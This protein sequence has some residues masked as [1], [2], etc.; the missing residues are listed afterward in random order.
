MVQYLDDQAFVGGVRAF[1]KEVFPEVHTP[2]F[3]P[4]H[5]HFSPS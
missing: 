4:F 3:L 1:W 5:F 2:F